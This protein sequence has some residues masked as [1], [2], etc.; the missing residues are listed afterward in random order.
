M[1]V[2]P[3]GRRAAGGPRA[4]RCYANSKTV[5]P[6]PAAGRHGAQ[7]ALQVT[8]RQ[9]GEGFLYWSLIGR[10][11]S[12]PCALI[13]SCAQSEC[14]QRGISLVA[15][16]L[17]HHHGQLQHPAVHGRTDARA[18]QS[19][20]VDGRGSHWVAAVSS[21]SRQRTTARRG[22]RHGPRCCTLHAARCARCPRRLRHS[23]QL[24]PSAQQSPMFPQTHVTHGS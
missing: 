11:T 13:G 14:S 23:G 5:G 2:R 1:A 9:K 21:S 8:A 4:A 12:T 24:D 3:S 15:V 7:R 20:T 10:T 18:E 19:R 16:A 17:E 22:S 6:R